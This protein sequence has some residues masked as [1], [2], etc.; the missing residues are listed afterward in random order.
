MLRRSGE[1]TPAGWRGTVRAAVAVLLIGVV[2]GVLPAA[3]AG[4]PAQTAPNCPCTLCGPTATPALL[5][6]PDPKAVEL[7]V[8]FRADVAGQVTGLRFYKGAQ[9]T[10]PHTGSLW[11]AGSTLLAQATFADETATGWQ[12]VSFGS[13]VAIT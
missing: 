5:T 13:P 11:T 6:D 12:Q 8:K 3:E 10:G 7:G 1:R 9:N 2:L 4:P